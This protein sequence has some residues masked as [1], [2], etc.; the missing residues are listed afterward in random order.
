MYTLMAL[1]MLTAAVLRLFLSL[2]SGVPVDPLPFITGSIGLLALLT[3]IP[4]SI[5]RRR[6]RRVSRASRERVV[7]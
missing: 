7:R 5:A 1:W 6:V 2:S 3:L 4:I